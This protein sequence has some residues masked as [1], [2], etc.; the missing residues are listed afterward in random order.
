MTYFA[1]FLT[2]FRLFQSF[3]N[4]FS[5]CKLLEVRRNIINDSVG[6]ISRSDTTRYSYDMTKL[7]FDPV[8]VHEFFMS[9][10]CCNFHREQDFQCFS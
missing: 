2:Y 4:F 6:S 9:Q 10:F 8:A 7:N 5:F 3:S 1:H